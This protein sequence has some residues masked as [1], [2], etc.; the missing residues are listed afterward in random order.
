VCGAARG[1]VVSARHALD[2][3]S[4]GVARHERGQVCSAVWAF[5]LCFS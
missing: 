1:H 2:R 4:Q 5:R 3:R